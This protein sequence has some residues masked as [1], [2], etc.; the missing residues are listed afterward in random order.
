[1][2]RLTV[3]LGGS[4]VAPIATPR[5]FPLDWRARAFVEACLETGVRHRSQGDDTRHPAQASM[6]RAAARS[7]MHTRGATR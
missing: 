2:A 6:M 4:L 1:M 7:P 3:H 5:R